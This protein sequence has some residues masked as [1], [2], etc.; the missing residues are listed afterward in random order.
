MAAKTSSSGGLL[1]GTLIVAGARVLTMASGFAVNMILARVLPLDQLGIYFLLTSLVQVG[2]MAALGGLSQS[3]IPLVAGT[4]ATDQPGQVHP[5][6]RAI[7]LLLLVAATL[8]SLVV[9]LFFDQIMG[10]LGVTGLGVSI[11]GL[12]LVWM[13]ARTLCMGG[14]HLLRAFGSMGQFGLM[15]TFLFNLLLLLA[16]TVLFLT[17]AVATLE[18]IVTWATVAAMAG[19]PLAAVFLW[20]H[21]RTLPGPEAMQTPSALFHVLRIGLPLWIIVLAGTALAD[22]HLWI[23]GALG[24]EE[25]AGLF[26]IVIRVVRLLAFPLMAL[27]MAIGPR[28]AQMWNKGQHDALRHL[29]RV[30]ATVIAVIAMCILVL[31]LL[32]GPQ[33]LALLFGAEFV[34]AWPAF[35]VL[36]VGQSVNGLTGLPM[37]VLSVT[38]AQRAAMVISLTSGALGVGTSL[39]LGRMD[40]LWGVAMGVSV[41]VVLQNLLALIYCRM[42]LGVNTLPTL[43]PSALRRGLR[44]GGAL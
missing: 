16:I 36:L 32:A 1:K 23:A 25:E 3:A 44:S 15:E 33:M 2:T 38:S 19:V 28:V 18:T 9:A 5:I 22:A 37:L 39:V 12:T 29:L 20:L 26:G 41:T 11:L 43:D 31:F 30:A 27:N 13:L 10:F 21:I 42:K 34:A 14:A 8:T 7:G 6:L 40:P 17:D 4:L 24:G 35:L